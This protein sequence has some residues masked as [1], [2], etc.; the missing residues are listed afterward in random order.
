M[1]EIEKPDEIF[2][3]VEER[4]KSSKIVCFTSHGNNKERV[5]FLLNLA[6]ELASS[7]KKILIIDADFTSPRICMLMNSPVYG[8]IL[9][10]ISQNGN[11][12]DLNE[13]YPGVRL[14]TLDMDIS[15]LS[16]LGIKKR[17][18][19][20]RYFKKS[21]LESDFVFVNFSPNFNLSLVHDIIKSGD[22]FV[23][24]TPTPVNGMINTYSLMKKVFFINKTAS[25][26][27]VTINTWS[28]GAIG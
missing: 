12:E 19:L 13:V 10:L 3:Q 5:F 20:K 6:L 21:E 28:T 27:I 2:P 7:G 25:L 24:L 17:L 11:T 8:S 26:G 22:D 23:F 18:Q 9:N 16:S 14:I 1:N 4:S 15:D